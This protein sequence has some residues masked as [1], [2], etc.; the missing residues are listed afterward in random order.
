MSTDIHSKDHSDRLGNIRLVSWNVRGIN[1]PVKRGKVLL[2][3]KSL[4]ADISFI[5]ETH[6]KKG[7]ENRL[8]SNWIAQMYQS[9]F[10][11][12]ARGVAILI[13]KNVP[14]V[15]QKTM[16]DINGRYIIVLGSI[17]SKQI[18]L[19]NL[20]AP[21]HDDPLFFQK[22]FKLIPSISESN[23]IIGGDFNCVLDNM[24]DRQPSQI[25]SVT[26]KSNAMLKQYMQSLN[27]VDIWRILNPSDRDFSFYSHV[28]KSYSRIDFFSA[29][30]KF[31]TKCMQVTISQY[32]NIRSCSPVS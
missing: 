17:N 19:V 10:S 27:I 20:Y 25:A 18:T 2:H 12:K 5:Q 28:H 30:F 9:T 11:T 32:Y 21:N 22:V 15:H 31:S 7:S 3:L 8:K 4:K 6:L 24:L 26:S 14:F 23:I 1:S 29:R 16:S 13:R